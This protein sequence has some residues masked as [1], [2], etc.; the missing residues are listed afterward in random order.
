VIVAVHHPIYSAYGSK[1]GSR[2]LKS[3]LENAVK[4]AGRTPEL[5][6]G[7]HVH[8]YQRFTG[9]LNDK[10]L[11]MI[12]AGAGGYS[13]KL[14]TLSK[15]F[16]KKKLP[17]AMVGSDGVLENFCDDQHGYLRITVTS[18]SILCEYVAVPDPSAPTTGPLKAFDSVTI[19]THY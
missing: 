19:R 13:L 3:V 14:H 15:A 7:G 12:V 10:D 16:H 9:T 6:L 4:I 18:K 17:M 5:I 8:D 1:P 11:P 2:H